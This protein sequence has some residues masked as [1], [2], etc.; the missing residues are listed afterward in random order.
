MAEQSS[1]LKKLADVATDLEY[2]TKL[3]T[4]ALETLGKIGT[5]EALLILLEIAGNEKLI[6]QERELALKHAGGII[7]SSH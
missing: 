5:H 3:R 2:P 1:E 7:K 4:G 6:R